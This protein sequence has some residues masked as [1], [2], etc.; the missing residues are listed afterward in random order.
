MKRLAVID[1]YLGDAEKLVD[2]QRL[3]PEI[4]VEV[5]RD[6]FDDEEAIAERLREFEMLLVNRRATP[7]TDTLLEKLPKLEFIVTSGPENPVIDVAAAR[8]RGIVVSGTPAT[9]LYNVAEYTWGLIFAIGRN[10]VLEDRMTRA[11]QWHT[12]VGVELRDK[13]IGILGLGKL[14]GDFAQMGSGFGVEFLAWSQNLTG[15]RCAEMGAERAASLDDLLTRS[16]FVVLLLRAG[17]RYQRLIGKRE[18]ELMKPTA[19]LI[20]TGRAALVDENAMIEALENGEIAGAALDVYDVEPLPLDHSLRKFDNVV[21]S[22]HVAVHTRECRQSRYDLILEDIQAFLDA[23]PIRELEVR[24]TQE[25][26]H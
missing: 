13:T 16:D 17:L 1:N 4:E 24:D 18:F 7:I 22:P 5:F 3:R 10:I 23:D 14:G 21:L 12:S 8:D 20:N 6:H 19:Y 2:W 9:N 11:G 15:E 25:A 26:H